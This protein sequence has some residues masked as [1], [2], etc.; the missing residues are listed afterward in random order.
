MS[1]GSATRRAGLAVAVGFALSAVINLWL[2]R[3][4]LTAGQLGWLALV[5]ALAAAATLAALVLL[6]RWWLRGGEPLM[7]QL[8]A[9]GQGRI[10]ERVQDGPVEWAP[11]SRAINVA[12][13][14]IKAQLD[15]RDHRLGELHA[16]LSV[17][18]VTQLSARA[19][20]MDR[21]ATLLHEPADAVGGIAL[22]RID[23]LAGLN[24]RAGRERADE[25]LKQ[26][27]T[28]LR[29]RAP[30]LVDAGGV[31]A[32]LNGADFGVLM[33][34]V[35]AEALNA[36]TR[37]LSEALHGLKQ[38]E[39]TD[40]PRVGWLAAGVFHG[41]ET[42]GAVMSRIDHALQTGEGGDAP[43]MMARVTRSGPAVSLAQWRSLIDE[44]LLT[45]RVDLQLSPVTT[46]DGITT[47]QLAQVRLQNAE[48]RAFGADE[49]LPS[50]LRTARIADIDLRV[51]ELA[52]ARIAGHEQARE[53]IAIRV[54]ARSAER[55]TFVSRFE[56]ALAGV[57]PLA[58]RLWVEF[59]ID[60]ERNVASVLGP[61]TT[62]LQRRGVHIG[63][64]RVVTPPEDLALLRRLGVGYLR[65][66]P[67]LGADLAGDGSAGKRRLLQLMVELG[68]AEGLRVL[69]GEAASDSDAQ[70]L[71]RV[72]IPCASPA[73]SP[74]TR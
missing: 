28:L 68:A 35:Q 64:R 6:S 62:M 23:D 16:E 46:L 22:L 61:L 21:L 8:D 30:R 34:C 12:L 72:G 52:L 33:P 26:V 57:G 42:I 2:L 69:A 11:M 39:L 58:Q 66:G 31:I 20:F 74:P 19:Q 45:G 38:R 49:V 4:T 73:E 43:W 7:A 54:S 3:A 37:E 32:R 17:D 71:R 40:R 10:T 65:L 59:D 29:T 44:A 60:G 56:E 18:P 27:A 1:I 67:A 70:L 51:A 63:L 53:E 14:R 5:H 47:Q 50:A 13:T 48:G 36:W 15:D 55:P 41:G 25:L 24:Q 9:A